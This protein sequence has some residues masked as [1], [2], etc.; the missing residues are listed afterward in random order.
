MKRKSTIIVSA[1]VH[2]TVTK[3]KE[4]IVFISLTKIKDGRGTKMLIVDYFAVSDT[5]VLEFIPPFKYELKKG[6]KWLEV[7]DESCA[8]DIKYTLQ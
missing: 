2:N 8:S 3:Q 5:N 6:K 1:Q 4:I 7:F